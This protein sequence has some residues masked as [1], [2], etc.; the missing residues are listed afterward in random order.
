MSN[1]YFQQRNKTPNSH[2]NKVFLLKYT[3]YR[4]REPLDYE[5]VTYYHATKTTPFTQ[6]RY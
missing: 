3:L 5:K 6:T 1:H 4:K 2:R